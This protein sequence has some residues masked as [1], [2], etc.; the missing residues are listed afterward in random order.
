[1]FSITNLIKFKLK[2]KK[3]IRFLLW[4][5]TFGPSQRLSIKSSLLLLVSVVV[6]YEVL[7]GLT[8]KAIM[9]SVDFAHVPV[10]SPSLHS[11]SGDAESESPQLSSAQ[12]KAQI[13]TTL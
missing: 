4:R 10:S 12:L 13:L 8:S 9:S 3:K 5:Q 7:C 11:L 1:M 6:Y 2:K